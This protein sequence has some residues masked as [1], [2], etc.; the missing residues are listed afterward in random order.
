MYVTPL[1][2][3]I[4][5]FKLLSVKN[6][7]IISYVLIMVKPVTQ[8]KNIYIRVAVLPVEVTLLFVRHCIWLPVRAQRLLVKYSPGVVYLTLLGQLPH[9]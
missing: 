7:I 3:P 6:N 2:N 9:F 4:D 1:S 8:Y 5:I